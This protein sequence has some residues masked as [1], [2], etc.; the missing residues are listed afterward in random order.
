MELRQK[1]TQHVIQISC[2]HVMITQK[3]I[4]VEF[5]P[6]FH[7]SLTNLFMPGP[8]HPRLHNVRT[9]YIFE[10]KQPNKCPLLSLPHDW[11][12]P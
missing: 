9:R 3:Y 6:S 2:E 4:H 5:Y 11:K 12:E 1:K 8:L 7:C 10:N